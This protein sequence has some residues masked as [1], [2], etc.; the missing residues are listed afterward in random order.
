[1]QDASPNDA[2]V[3]NATDVQPADD[4]GVDAP[5][6]W[7]WYFAQ[8][9]VYQYDGRHPP[10]VGEYPWSMGACTS[11]LS[12]LP[13][14]GCDNST[15]WCCSGYPEMQGCMCGATLGCLPPQMCCYLPDAT[16]PS[17]VDGPDACPGGVTPWNP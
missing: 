16:A 9:D 2:A 10:L 5:D 12:C 17:C 15:G 8:F 11:A 6:D 7:A 13:Y 1:M 4:A 3:D 14:A